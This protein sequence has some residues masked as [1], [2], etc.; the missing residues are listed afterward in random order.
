MPKNK[1]TVVSPEIKTIIQAA[2]EAGRSAG[3]AQADRAPLDAYK[4]TERRLYAL[5]TLRA[6]VEADKERLQDLIEDGPQQK[7]KSIARFSR[8][9]VRLT[10]EEI[11]EALAQDLRATIEADEYEIHTIETALATIQ[12]DPYYLAVVGKYLGQM[13]DEEIAEKAYCDASTIRR[14]RG[15]LVRQLAIWLYGAQAIK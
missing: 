11:T 12:S 5:P 3:V 6:K 9:G 10:P 7:S 4:A 1:K 15:R 2:V 14:N 13:S 8:S